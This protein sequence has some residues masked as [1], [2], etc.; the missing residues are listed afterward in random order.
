MRFKAMVV[1]LF[2]FII[3]VGCSSTSNAPK[4]DKRHSE[5]EQEI[6]KLTTETMPRID[7][8]TANI[9]LIRAFV[10]QVLKFDQ[11]QAQEY[12]VVSG[13]DRSYEALLDRKSVV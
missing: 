11:T 4:Q 6:F 10:A 12:V 8:S 7:G 3:L 5:N 2:I 1:L 9:P 13:T